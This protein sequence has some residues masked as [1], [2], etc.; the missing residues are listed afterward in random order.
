MF[1]NIVC[2][3]SYHTSF[4]FAKILSCQSLL[5]FALQENIVSIC[6]FY[7]QFVI[8]FLL[9]VYLLSFFIYVL[10]CNIYYLAQLV[11]IFLAHAGGPSVSA[12]I[13]DTTATVVMLRAISVWLSLSLSIS[14]LS[15]FISLLSVLSLLTP[16]PP[17]S[18]SEPLVC[19]HRNNH[20]HYQCQ[21]CHCLYHYYWHHCRHRNASGHLVILN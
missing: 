19:G 18:C 12:I 15:L 14:S 10:A 5:Y 3:F 1:S 7:L 16:L 11:P 6:I 21:H 20:Y 8:C 2:S 4:F 9:F 13:I 17:S